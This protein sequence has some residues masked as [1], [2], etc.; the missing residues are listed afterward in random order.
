[1]IKNKDAA[2]QKYPSATDFSYQGI[3]DFINV[4]SETFVFKGGED[5]VVSAAARPWM[6]E[7]LPQ[8]T[9]DSA[10]DICLKKEG[11]LCVVYVAKDQASRDQDVVNT[12]NEIS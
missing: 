7:K 2:P 3:F 4:Y 5:E 8:I 10:N 9:Q 1:M 11:A 6:S 12:L